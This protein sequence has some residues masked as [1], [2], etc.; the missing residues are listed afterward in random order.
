MLRPTVKYMIILHIPKLL[1]N[2]IYFFFTKSK[3][4][5]KE[6]KFR[7]QKNFKKRLLQKQKSNQHI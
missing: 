5:W 6:R 7:R 3:N 2:K 1:Q 4:E